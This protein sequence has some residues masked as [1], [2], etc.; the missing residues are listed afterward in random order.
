MKTTVLQSHPATSLLG[1]LV[2]M[3]QNAMDK[4][5]PYGFEDDNGFHYDTQPVR[6]RHAVRF[7]HE[8]LAQ[9]ARCYRTRHP[10]ASF[11]DCRI[12]TR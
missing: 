8:P 7:H 11:H 10:Q 1:R 2:G 5:F 6:I 3:L 4:L 12:T 9:H